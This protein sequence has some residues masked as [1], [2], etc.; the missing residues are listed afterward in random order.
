MSDK[1]LP[2][3]RWGRIRKPEEDAGSYLY[4]ELESGDGW[5]KPPP[6]DAI[7]VWHRR[8]G[9]AADDDINNWTVWLHAQD[10]KQWASAYEFAEWLPEGS[11]PDWDESS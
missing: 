8:P 5:K 1:P 6:D 3:N 11:E 4:V 9:A 10:L 7:R 2:L